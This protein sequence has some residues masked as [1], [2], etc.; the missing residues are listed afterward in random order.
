MK[1]K[2]CRHLDYNSEMDPRIKLCS[3]EEYECPKVWYWDRREIAPAGSQKEV[4]YCRLRG[5][6]NGI[7]QCVNPGELPCFEAQEEEK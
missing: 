2:G 5:R 7:F 4:Q 1:Y 6:I 3:L